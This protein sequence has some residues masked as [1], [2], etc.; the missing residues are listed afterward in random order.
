METHRDGFISTVERFEARLQRL[1]ALSL[2]SPEEDVDERMAMTVLLSGAF[3][4][5]LHE[6]TRDFVLALPSR[7]T[8]FDNLPSNVRRTHYEG[9]ARILEQAAKKDWREIKSDPASRFG[10]A[11]E[12]VQRLGTA[13]A[14]PYRLV[15]E[16]FVRID[17]NVGPDSLSQILRRVAVAKPWET[18]VEK[19]PSTSYIVPAGPAR[20]GKLHAVLTEFRLARNRCAHGVASGAVPAWS[21]LLEFMTA[22]KAT[23]LGFIAALQA[24]L[25]S[26]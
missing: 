19:I 3:E 24:R 12:I 20:S 13:G 11:D 22:L 18:L 26:L 14:Q 6:S 4:R 8:S 21:D 23:A 7:V 17:S 15:W 2:Q 25:A 9:G 5:F 16:A 10:Q 1:S